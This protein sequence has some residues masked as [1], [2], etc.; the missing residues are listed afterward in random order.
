MFVYRSRVP[1][2]YCNE[3]RLVSEENIK[4]TTLVLIHIYMHIYIYVIYIGFFAE[5]SLD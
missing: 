3:K 1:P 5:T 2:L 4:S